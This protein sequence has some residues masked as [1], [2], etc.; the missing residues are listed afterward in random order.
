M[1]A[2][3]T[4][5]QSFGQRK[6]YRVPATG[7]LA[8]GSSEDFNGTN[9]PDKAL[10]LHINVTSDSSNKSTSFDVEIFETDDFD[11]ADSIFLSTG[12]NHKL[13]DIFVQP[14]RYRDRDSS[15]EL[16]LRITNNAGSASYFD[17]DIRYIPA[18]PL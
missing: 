16:H 17:V 10:L 3:E 6:T 8:V 7:T 5:Y 12:N 1:L 11:D 2:R 13:R 18:P 4:F 14:I 9:F 15:E